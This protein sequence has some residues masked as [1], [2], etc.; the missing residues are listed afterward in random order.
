MIA[1]SEVSLRPDEKNGA[2]RTAVAPLLSCV[3]ALYVVK[4]QIIT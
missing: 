3:H 4:F 2:S 1:H